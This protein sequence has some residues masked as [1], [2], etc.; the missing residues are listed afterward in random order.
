MLSKSSDRARGFHP[1]DPFRDDEQRLLCAAVDLS[2]PRKSRK[3]QP[4]FARRIT[5]CP[6]DE[7]EQ[8]LFQTW[9]ENSLPIGDDDERC[10]Q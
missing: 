4:K 10:Y 7:P 5:P 6:S 9:L 8:P 2:P 1:L 3:K